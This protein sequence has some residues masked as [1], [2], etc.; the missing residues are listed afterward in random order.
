MITYQY[1]VIVSLSILWLGVSIGL[2]P[3]VDDV[4]PSMVGPLRR[5]VTNYDGNPFT[6][7]SI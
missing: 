3:S 2:Y 1:C 6:I 4:S 7:Y 5:G